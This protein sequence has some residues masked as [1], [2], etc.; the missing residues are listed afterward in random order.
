M[1]NNNKKE[2]RNKYYTRFNK[3]N[4][5]SNFLIELYTSTINKQI[6]LCIN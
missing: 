5:I 6:F 1:I 2:I 4:N 3:F